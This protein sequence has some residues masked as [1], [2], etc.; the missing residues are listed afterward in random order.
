MSRGSGTRTF[1]LTTTHHHQHTA[2]A[3]RSLIPRNI[4]I[5][6][7]GRTADVNGL[8]LS[9]RH[10]LFLYCRFYRRY[11]TLFHSQNTRVKSAG[12]NEACRANVHENA[13][14]TGHGTSY[15]VP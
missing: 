5:N 12:N 15:E 13:V 7:R 10:R 6:A 11:M 4:V 9:T 3:F 1:M 14:K 8:I 2:D